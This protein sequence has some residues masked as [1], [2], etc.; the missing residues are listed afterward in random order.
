MEILFFIIGFAID[1][2]TKVWAQ[3]KL[4]KIDEIV[5]IKNFFSFKYLENTGAAFGVLQNKTILLVL[6]TVILTAVIVFYIVK[7]KPKSKLL[8]I[9]LTLIVTGGIGNLYDRIV[10][11]FV[12]DFIKMH[13]ADKYSFPTFNVADMMVTVGTILFLLYVVKEE[14]NGDK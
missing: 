11:K 12:T 8:R 6:I 4:S 13:Y 2:I 3:T 10:N 7:Y 1:R 14:K 5:I 9:S